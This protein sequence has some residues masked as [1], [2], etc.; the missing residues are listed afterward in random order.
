MTEKNTNNMDDGRVIADM[1]AIERPRLLLPR[2]PGKDNGGGCNG[3]VH[4][5]PPEEGTGV[6][7]PVAS[8]KEEMPKEDR[9]AYLFGAMGAAL[10][11]GLIFLAAAGVAILLMILF[12][13]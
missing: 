11:I 4:P 9:R 1:S 7:V 3:D 2:R 12:W 6:N 8:P 10:V 5:C 13:T